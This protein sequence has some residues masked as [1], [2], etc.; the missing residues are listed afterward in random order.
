[1]ISMLRNETIAFL[2]HDVA[3]LMRARFD[4]HAR[5]LGATRQQWRVLINLASLGEGPTQAE[6]AERIDV[7]P[8][9][10]CRMIDRL[11]EAGLVE[12]RA[13]P[14]DR[15][16]RRLHLLPPAHQ[17]VEK[18]SALAVELEDQALAVLPP[19]ARIALRDNLIRL[20][21]GLRHGEDERAVA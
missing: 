7:E 9:T 16:V 10:L 11:S 5:A 4:G 19:A 12:R 21:D 3:R 18:L 15:R 14:R 20:R 2:V 17:L 6:L 1:M 13:D 8:I